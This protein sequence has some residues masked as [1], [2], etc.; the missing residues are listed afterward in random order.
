MSDFFQWAAGILSPPPP[1]SLPEGATPTLGDTYV[2]FE[3]VRNGSVI[4]A[5]ALSVGVLD[6]ST[7]LQLATDTLGE[8][9]NSEIA[10][11]EACHQLDERA[12]PDETDDWEG[13]E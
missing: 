9:C 11:E 13:E 4:V 3:L 2:G 10:K 5:T 7:T 12:V 1:S 6:P 8:F